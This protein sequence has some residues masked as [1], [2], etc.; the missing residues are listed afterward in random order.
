[1]HVLFSE[2]VG[3]SYQGVCVPSSTLKKLDVITDL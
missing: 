3:F 1:M 2:K